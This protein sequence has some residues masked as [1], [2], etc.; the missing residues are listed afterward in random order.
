MKHFAFFS[1]LA[2]LASSFSFSNVNQ[3]NEEISWGGL[4]ATPV[5]YE[6]DYT[7]EPEAKN[8]R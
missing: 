8:A 1:T 3:T 6:R 5:A 7:L 2:L 4:K